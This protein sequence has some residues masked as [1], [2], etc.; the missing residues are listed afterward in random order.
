MAV[1]KACTTVP[2]SLF[3]LYSDSYIEMQVG[4]VLDIEKK[5]TS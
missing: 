1:Q 5:I 3:E 2:F 4:W